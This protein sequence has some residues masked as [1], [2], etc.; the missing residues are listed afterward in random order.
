M[1]AKDFNSKHPHGVRIFRNRIPEPEEVAACRAE[2]LK[3]HE[4]TRLPDSVTPLRNDF[5]SMKQDHYRGGV[6][7]T[8]IYQLD[9]GGS[10]VLKKMLVGK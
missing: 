7:D 4:A 2:W 6:W 3:Q 1:P 5:P 8:T 9:P 10:G